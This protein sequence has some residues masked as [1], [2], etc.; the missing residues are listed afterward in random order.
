MKGNIEINRVIELQA[1]LSNR[2]ISKNYLSEMTRDVC[3]HC[4]FMMILIM[5]IVL[6]KASDKISVTGF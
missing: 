2:F 6:F 3:S 1:W 5:I 4:S